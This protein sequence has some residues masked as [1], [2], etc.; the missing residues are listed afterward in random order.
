MRGSASLRTVRSLRCLHCRSEA[1]AQADH[2][3]DPSSCC[4]ACSR[5]NKTKSCCVGA[6]D[7]RLW[8]S[9][10][11]AGVATTGAPGWGAFK[12]NGY[13]RA[14]RG[15]PSPW[16]FRPPSVAT[17][18]GPRLPYSCSR[19]SNIRCGGVI[20]SVVRS[21]A[22]GKPDLCHTPRSNC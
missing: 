2:E 16:V 13:W 11:P 21:S 10:A 22:Y 8:G 6:R 19:P 5:Q 15:C 14:Y 20:R 9:D 1:L 17:S 3:R 4:Q 12:P 18:D 7:D